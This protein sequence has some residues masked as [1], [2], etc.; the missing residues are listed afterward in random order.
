[1]PPTQAATQV[2]SRIVMTSF[3]FIPS[4]WRAFCPCQHARARAQGIVAAAYS[5]SQV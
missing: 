4:R 1:L 3:M 2:A 5:K